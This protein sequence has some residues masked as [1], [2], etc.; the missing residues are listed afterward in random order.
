M[1]PKVIKGWNAAPGAPANWDPEK[2]GGP[3]GILH[4]RCTGSPWT[5]GSYCE[6]AWEPAPKEL[7][8]L[9][10]GGQIVLR[11][12]GW[13]VPVSMYVEPPEPLTAKADV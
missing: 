6:S 13:Q 2:Q 1:L 8:M 3:C 10:A 7:A 5:P 4:I 12:V 11:V 9:N